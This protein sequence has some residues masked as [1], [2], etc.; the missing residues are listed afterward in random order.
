MPALTRAR[1]GEPSSRLQLEGVD[2]E[3]VAVV[4]A[5]QFGGQ[6]GHRMRAKVRRQVADAQALVAIAAAPVSGATVVSLTFSAT[7]RRRRPVA[8]RVGSR[9]SIASAEV[10]SIWSAG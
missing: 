9:L 10:A 6:D 7:K 8:G 5:V 1:I 4:Q 2:L 3:P